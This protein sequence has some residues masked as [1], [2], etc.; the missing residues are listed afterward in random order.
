MSRFDPKAIAV[1]M[2]LSLALDV[3]GSAV[4][5]AS[6]GTGLTEG[7]SSDDVKAV[8]DALPQNTGFLL[9][10][11]T[12]GIF[13]TGL[14]GYIAARMARAY[15]YFNALAIALLGI[16]LGLVLTD[17]W[18]WWFDAIGYLSMPPAALLGGHIARQPKA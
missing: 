18:P 17:D 12:Y 7:M 9:A 8:L 11:L 14:G 13:T 4:L 2:L 6:F 10:S 5:L 15:P 1:A 3:I 16:L